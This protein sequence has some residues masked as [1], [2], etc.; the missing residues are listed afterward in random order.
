MN[1]ENEEDGEDGAFTDFTRYYGMSKITDLVIDFGYVKEGAFDELLKLP[2]ALERLSD[3][4]EHFIH[5]FDNPEI[6]IGQYFLP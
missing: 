5:R 2:A 6:G 4:Y 1:Y 3:S